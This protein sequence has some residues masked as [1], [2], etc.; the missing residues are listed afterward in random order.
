M[1]LGW[2]TLIP[3]VKIVQ[4]VDH[5]CLLLLGVVVV[6]HTTWRLFRGGFGV[7]CLPELEEI[8]GLAGLVLG[9][10]LLLRTN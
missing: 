10:C 8:R 7:V 9:R 5:F 2:V 3:G 6:V 1:R 4:Q